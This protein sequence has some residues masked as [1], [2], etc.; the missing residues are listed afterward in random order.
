MGYVRDDRQIDRREHRSTRAVIDHLVPEHDL[1]GALCDDAQTQAVDAVQGFGWR[2]SPVDRERW[3]GSDVVTV[4]LG[5]IA[6]GVSQAA[7]RF[8]L[9]HF[10]LRMLAHRGFCHLPC[11]I[12]V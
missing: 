1:L 12:E 8:T 9:E 11:Q 6:D 5:N 3:N 2:T 7:H 4:G 10:W